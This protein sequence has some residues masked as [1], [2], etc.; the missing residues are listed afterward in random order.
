MTRIPLAK[1]VTC[2]GKSGLTY[3]P[4]NVSSGYRDP[5]TARIS[6]LAYRLSSNGLRPLLSLSLSDNLTKRVR[7]RRKT[8]LT[9]ESALGKPSIC[10]A[11]RVSTRSRTIAIITHAY[12]LLSAC[13]REHKLRCMHATMR[14]VIPSHVHASTLIEL[15]HP[16]IRPQARRSQQVFGRV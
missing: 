7:V 2:F 9:S 8:F 16:Y 11:L 12:L 15:R 6:R 1:I 5:D 13:L 10:H 3:A 4:G 14:L